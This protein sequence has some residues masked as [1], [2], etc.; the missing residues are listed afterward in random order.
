MS[1]KNP[2]DKRSFS[3]GPQKGVKREAPTG[4]KSRVKIKKEGTQEFFAKDKSDSYTFN[5]AP[6]NKSD[7]KRDI[8]DEAA[9]PKKRSAFMANLYA[10]DD[11][12]EDIKTI[13]G[14]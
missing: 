8:L 5:K 2:N 13:I 10:N 7:A 11:E 9:K 1:S 14:D 6:I 4:D 12:A 3:K